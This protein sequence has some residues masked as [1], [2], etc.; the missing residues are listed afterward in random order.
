MD[1]AVAWGD[2]EP[3]QYNPNQLPS[4]AI[5]V[6]LGGHSGCE[7]DNES[8]GVEMADNSF[9]ICQECLEN[10][11]DRMGGCNETFEGFHNNCNSGSESD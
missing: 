2:I 9:P 11:V 1:L 4:P 5:S 3:L 6:D 10:C 7:A 8:D